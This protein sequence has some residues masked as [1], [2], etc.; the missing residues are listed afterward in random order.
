MQI[1]NDWN[2]SEQHRLGCDASLLYIM[3]C[4]S[5][6]GRITQMLEKALARLRT[7]CTSVDTERVVRLN[8]ARAAVLRRDSALAHDQLT[9]CREPSSETDAMSRRLN[10]WCMEFIGDVALLDGR[11]AEALERYTALERVAVREYAPD[12]QWRALVGRA[13][14]LEALERL[15]EALAA[16]AEADRLLDSAVL[17][18]PIGAGRDTFLADRGRGPRRHV[19]LLLRIG[20]PEN[21][22]AALKIARRARA[23]ALR[24]LKQSTRLD[25]LP[26]EKRE[27][28]AKRMGQF[29]RRRQALDR[30][31][32]H[33][34]TAPLSQEKLAR[35]RRQ[36][37]ADFE[38]MLQTLDQ[39]FAL[40]DPM[41]HPSA[42]VQPVPG[43]LM[44]L[45]FQLMGGRWA[46]FVTDSTS[47][48]PHV[49]LTEPLRTASAMRQGLWKA[50]FPYLGR[51]DHLRYLSYGDFRG[52][53]IAEIVE[54]APP[55]GSSKPSMA[56][57]PIVYAL[58]LFRPP[59]SAPGIES[60]V[61]QNA[62]IVTDPDGT[63]HTS[64]QVGA[65]VAKRLRD[66]GWTVQLLVGEAATGE[67]VRKALSG[68]QLF[69]YS[70]HA[71]FAG[72]G[73][74]ESA[75]RLA[76]DTRLTIG[77]VLALSEAPKRVVLSGCETGRAS[78]NAPA[79]GMGL[80]QAFVSVGAE[81]VVAT[82]RPVADVVAARV[83]LDLYQHGFARGR[84]RTVTA[85]TALQ[86]ALSNLRQSEPNAD[87]TAFRLIV[88]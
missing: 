26:A 82:I 50:I 69:H 38:Q 17:Q 61:V 15:P 60:P 30:A 42:E 54:S 53:D 41:A 58:D 23:R 1:Q 35:H 78:T 27:L 73:G 51:G 88:P 24:T 32:A 45:P 55:R 46:I 14:G 75:L 68:V 18:V 85:A 6:G 49:F 16:Y 81:S 76:G 5:L 70:G 2:L 52:I 83:S 13:T 59:S 47:S 21:R 9:V 80:A 86:Q 40:L 87:W 79:G 44:V 66:A 29:R 67:A 64:R 11:A 84:H 10:R 37:R 48:A 72:W 57:L 33:T 43:A 22:R 74:W 8:L 36:I 65:T 62:L 3:G 4:S 39:A 71:V 19:A 7:D 34:R 77:D 20:G 31:V 25:A 12:S 56:R 63:L 28:W